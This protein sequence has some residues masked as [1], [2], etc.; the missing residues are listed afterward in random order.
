[1][2][3]KLDTCTIW[4]GWHLFYTLEEKVKA[5]KIAGIQ[6]FELNMKDLDKSAH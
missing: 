4:M 6:G 1:M 3:Q 2:Y 5:A